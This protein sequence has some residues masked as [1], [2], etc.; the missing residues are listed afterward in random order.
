MYFRVQALYLLLVGRAQQEV[1]HL[2]LERVVHL[3][4]RHP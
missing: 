3:Q 2:R 1:V 4:Q